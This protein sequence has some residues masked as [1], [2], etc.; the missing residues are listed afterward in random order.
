MIPEDYKPITSFGQDFA[1]AN[2]F[3]TDAIKDTYE[4]SLYY[5][6]SSPEYMQEFILVL[7]QWCWKTYHDGNQK[8]AELYSK[9]YDDAYC[10]LDNDYDKNEY[11]TNEEIQSMLRWLD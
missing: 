7:N 1:I 5:A 6:E 2:K 11:F 10:I 8:Y 3:G 4:R 9:L